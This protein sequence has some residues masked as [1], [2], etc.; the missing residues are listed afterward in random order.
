MARAKGKYLVIILTIAACVLVGTTFAAIT[1]NQNLASSGTIQTGPNVGV[2]SNSAC[3]LPI[4]SLN[5]GTIQAGSS[6]TV[7]IYIEDTGGSQ[8]VPS[9]TVS[10]WSPSTASSYITI[11]WTTLPPEIQPGVSGAIAVTLTLT[12][13]STIT[14]ITSFTNLI[15]ISGTG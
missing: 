3:T 13:S 12:V 5:W 4:T 10:N 11:A 2:Y 9:I 1:I 14:G 6:A 8:M 15:T 7:T